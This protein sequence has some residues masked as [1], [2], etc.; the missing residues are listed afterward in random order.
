MNNGKRIIGIILI[1]V[2]IV[3]MICWEKWG[4]EILFY[5]EIVVINRDIEKNTIITSDM[6]ETKKIQNPSNDALTTKI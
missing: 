1:I 2:S 5:K 6:L 3:G 4:R